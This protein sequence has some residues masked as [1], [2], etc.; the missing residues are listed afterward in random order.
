MVAEGHA[1][2]RGDVLEER[3]VVSCDVHKTVQPGDAESNLARFQME[4]M[5][6]PKHEHHRRK[7]GV[8]RARRTRRHQTH[9]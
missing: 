8:H 1:R 4:N 3:M 2:H 6:L 5:R 9:L 7:P